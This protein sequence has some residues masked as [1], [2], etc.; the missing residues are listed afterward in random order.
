[1]AG[2]GNGWSLTYVQGKS[3]RAEGGKGELMG[4]LSTNT[5]M[6]GTDVV[7]RK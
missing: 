7:V 6:P 2:P 4:S 5:A 1:M 3:D